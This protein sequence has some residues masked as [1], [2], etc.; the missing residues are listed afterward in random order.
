M[1]T[2]VSVC[3]SYLFQMYST[4]TE[5]KCGE[6]PSCIILAAQILGLGLWHARP[7]LWHQCGHN[8]PAT[9]YND[10]PLWSFHQNCRG[11]KHIFT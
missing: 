8:A 9:R 7:H 2:F 11:K 10:S 5:T 3:P 1:F 4:K 6:Q